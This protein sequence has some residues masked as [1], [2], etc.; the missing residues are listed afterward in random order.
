MHEHQPTFYQ[1][2]SP[3]SRRKERTTRFLHEDR[4]V[5]EKGGDPHYFSDPALNWL[6]FG[7]A[8]Y[9]QMIKFGLGDVSE[10]VIYEW[11]QSLKCGEIPTTTL[12]GTEATFREFDDVETHLRNYL[13]DRRRYDALQKFHARNCKSKI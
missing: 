11:A 13:S 9:E 4:H 3:G 12:Y 10:S 6:L 5:V 8:T 2:M 7:N 1:H